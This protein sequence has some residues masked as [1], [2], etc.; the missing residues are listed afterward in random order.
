MKKQRKLKILR[1][2]GLA[3]PICE[4]RSNKGI[5][6]SQGERSAFIY[7]VRKI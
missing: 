5:N 1:E 6:G 2:C 4:K 3:A 7:V